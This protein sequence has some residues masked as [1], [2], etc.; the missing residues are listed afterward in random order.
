MLAA[1]R[2]RDPTL[3]CKKQLPP[4]RIGVDQRPS[5]DGSDCSTEEAF[6]PMRP[7]AEPRP[8]KSRL[9][10][11]LESAV[12]DAQPDAEALRLLRQPSAGSKRSWSS[13]TNTPSPVSEEGSAVSIG[14]E[15]DSSRASKLCDRE[16]EGAGDSPK[17][18][19]KGRRAS[20]PWS[21]EEDGMLQRA[22]LEVGPKRWS[23]IALAVP[24]RS[25]KQ[26]RL[27][28]C[29]QIDPGIKHESWTDKEDAT[30]L[31]A[32]RR[33]FTH[34]GHVPQ[35]GMGPA[36]LL[37]VRAW[38]CSQAAEPCS[39]CADGRRCARRRHKALGS[40]WTEISKLIPGRTDNAIKNRWN[41]TLSRK[42]EEQAR[43]ACGKCWLGGATARHP[44][45]P[46]LALW[47]LGCATHSGRA[48]EPL[49]AQ[50]G[51][52]GGCGREAWPKLPIMWLSTRR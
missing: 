40:R 22:V 11:V 6:D 15:D 41:G 21:A 51:G 25:G 43:A 31:R 1:A 47:G 28:W 49:R 14:P 50:M 46:G 8:I 4:T 33:G 16:Q 7:D 26:C 48:T 34:S 18:D 36:A 27:R 12:A 17:G 30:I 38:G 44:G 37:L 24:G 35:P 29:N 42:A 2:I 45:L 23:A 3:S 20:Q 9:S 19:P 39:V 5:S 32:Y 13:R 10:L 52:C